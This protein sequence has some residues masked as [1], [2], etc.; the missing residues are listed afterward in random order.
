[1]LSYSGTLVKYLYVTLELW[2]DS[3]ILYLVC[4]DINVTID[5]LSCLAV[6]SFAN[7]ILSQLKIFSF[8]KKYGF[9]TEFTKLIG[10]IRSEDA[11]SNVYL[12]VL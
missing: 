11:Q 2:Y 3:V 9:K 7:L 4:C 12:T 8:K 1:M 5:M 10:E 6:Y